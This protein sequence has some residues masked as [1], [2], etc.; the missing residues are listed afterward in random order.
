M[1]TS[2]VQLPS[3]SAN[4]KLTIFE[5]RTRDRSNSGSSTRSKINLPRGVGEKRWGNVFVPT[6]ISYLGILDEPWHPESKQT[7]DAL[8]VIWN[9]VYPDKPY[10]IEGPADLVYTI[11]SEYLYL[12]AK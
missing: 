10:T 2:V 6:F 12:A 3:G 1:A 4:D 5:V 8:Q 7:I 11:V 9:A